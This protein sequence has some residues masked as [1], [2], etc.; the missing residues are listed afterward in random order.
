MS[1]ILVYGANGYTGRLVVKAALEQGIN[2]TLAGRSPKAIQDL[3]KVSGFPYVVFGV[4][5][6]DKLQA[7]LDEH[8]VLLNCAGPFPRTA[9]QLI[10]GCLRTSTHYLDITGEIAQFEKIRMQHEYAVAT[11]I[12]MIPGV[13]FDVVPTDCLAKKLADRFED[14]RSLELAFMNLGGG[15]SHGTLTTMLTNLGHG[16]M[17]RIDGKL[18]PVPLAKHGKIIDF[19]IKKR[20]CISIPWGDVSTAAVGTAIRDT[21][22]YSAAPKKYFHV[23][24]AQGLLNPILKS[25]FFKRW[26]QKKIDREVFGPTAEQNRNGRSLV[27]G[28]L[29]APDGR[30]LE[31]RFEGPESYW[32]TALTALHIAQKCVESPPKPGYHTP[33]TAFGPDL[34]TEIP[35]CRFF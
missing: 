29:T 27:W 3:A 1:K 17:E 12:C 23:L 19:G 6:I 18:V 4:D 10:A 5:E 22:V 20:F 31:L 32:L 30:H 28:K 21:V 2:I 13:G 9:P 14:G 15:I 16:G 7:A 11:G 25:S 26:A 34:I 35:G 33:A 24:K 8:E